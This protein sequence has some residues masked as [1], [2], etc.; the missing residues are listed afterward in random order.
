[1]ENN[2]ENTELRKQKI[3]EY[4]RQEYIKNSDKIKARSKEYYYRKKKELGIPDK[5]DKYKII[6]KKIDDFDDK[7]IFIVHFD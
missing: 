1:M 5:K 7:D 6:I 2:K 3:K 4:K